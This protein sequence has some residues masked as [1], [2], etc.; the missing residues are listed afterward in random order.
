MLNEISAVDTF[1]QNKNIIDIGRRIDTSEVEV[2]KN[3]IHTDP[4]LTIVPNTIIAYERLQSE[5]FQCETDFLGTETCP[6]GQEICPSYEEFDNGYSVKHH[7]VKSFVKICPINHILE[8]DRCYADFNGDNNKDYTF[9]K[10]TGGYKWS[11][12]LLS[13]SN[14]I[15][16]EGKV[17]I[18]PHGYLEVRHFSPSACDNDNNYVYIKVDNKIIKSV[19]CGGSKDTGYIKAYEN[20]TNESVEID[21]YYYDRHSGGGYDVSYFEEYIYELTSLLPSTYIIES[22]SNKLYFYKKTSC[23]INTIEQADGSCKMEYDWYSYHCPMNSNYYQNSWQIRDEGKDCGSAVCTNS[24]VPPTNNCIRVDYT[25]PSNPNSKCGKSVVDSIE[26]ED[27]FVWNNRCERLESYC[28]SSTY[29]AA[30]DICENI[31]R[32]TKL[33]KNDTDV[34]DVNLNK[35]VSNTEICK[36]G[37]YNNITKSCVIDFTG[38]CEK[39]GYVYDSKTQSCINP[40]KNL[41]SNNQ[42]TYDSINNICKGSI[43]ICEVGYTLNNTTNKCEKDICGELGTLN[44]NTR[45]ET[46]NQCEGIITSLGT[47]IP[48]V[49]Q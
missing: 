20:N 33:C 16:R 27:G 42:Y 38:S 36:D 41:C 3:Y 24:S 12:I 14:S 11:G 26:C 45:C 18:P 19:W 39:E 21:Y 29:N 30:K 13:G 10:K 17:T 46:N 4:N 47:C 7:T 15:T 9:Y 34:Y 49:V 43:T 48:N 32:Y 23:P 6:S 35:C 40:S 8:N 5:L 37:I 31:K 22:I 28:G 25:C 1:L 2:A 44:S